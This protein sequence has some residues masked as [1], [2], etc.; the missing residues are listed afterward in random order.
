MKFSVMFWN[1]RNFG[2]AKNPSQERIKKVADH[3]KGLDPD[4]FCLCEIWN[5]DALRLLLTDKLSDYD[6][7]ITDGKGDIE[8]LTGWKRCT[9]Q[10]VLFTQRH[11]FREDNQYLRPGALTSIKFNNEFFNFLFLH[12]KA[13]S[14]SKAY[15][16]RQAMFRK[17]WSLKRRLDKLSGGDDK[18]KFV[19][20]GDLNTVGR[21][22]DR[23]IISAE[24]ELE[25]LI[26]DAENNG[27]RM[28]PKTHEN[29]WR[30]WLDDRMIESSIDHVLATGNV[31]FHSFQD[32]EE[33]EVLVSGWNGLKEKKRN[34]F[35][36]DLSDHSALFCKVISED[37][38]V[39]VTRSGKKYHTGR[40]RTLRRGK[41]EIP[42]TEAKQKY[43]R[44]SRCSPPR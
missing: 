14:D 4:L 39:Y 20:M 1:V 15:N 26:E 10:Q 34:E 8:L 17:V 21:R 28:L 5:K 18:A 40:C 31:S 12:T 42:L 25:T 27:M 22:G 37:E 23:D 38:V 43:S 9:F 24:Q 35:I 11:K 29:T 19:V 44:C 32:G 16:Y 2:E 6:F 30:G 36:K 7:A 3:I 33:Q 13:W 41:I